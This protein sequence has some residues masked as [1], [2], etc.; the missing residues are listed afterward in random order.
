MPAKPLK[1]MPFC[2]VLPASACLYETT[3]FCPRTL[4][5][6]SLRLPLPAS[7]SL[8]SSLCRRVLKSRVVQ[9]FGQ[10]GEGGSGTPGVGGQNPHPA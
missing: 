3:S 4:A 7:S 9:F 10:P 6:E 5:G 8:L 1:T 2:L